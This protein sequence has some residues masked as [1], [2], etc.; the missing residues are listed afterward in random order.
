MIQPLFNVPSRRV[1]DGQV[2]EGTGGGLQIESNPIMD[3]AGVPLSLQE[4]G[5]NVYHAML[6]RGH[7]EW[8][9]TRAAL[10]AM[11]DADSGFNADAYL[12]TAMAQARGMSDNPQYNYMNN[13]GWDASSIQAQKKTSELS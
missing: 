4:H 12:R 9:A 10:K 7:D 5:A 8:T 2:I 11:M 13:L 6:S 1:S 3:A